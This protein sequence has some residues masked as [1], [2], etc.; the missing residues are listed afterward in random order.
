MHFIHFSIFYICG[1]KHLKVNPSLLQKLDNSLTSKKITHS[2]CT[3][4]KVFFGVKQ[5]LTAWFF[6]C[7][8]IKVLCLVQWSYWQFF[9]DSL[10]HLCP[11]IQ[12]TANCIWWNNVYCLDILPCFSHMILD[13]LFISIETLIQKIIIN[14][15]QALKLAC[16]IYLPLV[17]L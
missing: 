1:P 17:C 15:C 2:W 6:S 3:H 14:S 9:C 16:L 12:Q 5:L 8:V 4:A 7:C 11:S 13:K 10:V